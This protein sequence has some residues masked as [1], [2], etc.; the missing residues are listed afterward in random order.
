MRA[1]AL[2]RHLG[3]GASTLS[4]SVQRLTKMGYIVRTRD[5]GDAR[6][7]A[8]RL[9]AQGLHAMQSSSVLDT[10]RVGAMLDRLSPSDR[11]RAVDG[12]RLLAQA[13]L[14]GAGEQETRAAPRLPMR[15]K[16]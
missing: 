15:G 8:L 3:I 1:A 7:L 14:I 16:Q 4:A 5:A 2:A 12:L 13:A 11:T 6:A 9:S 10:T